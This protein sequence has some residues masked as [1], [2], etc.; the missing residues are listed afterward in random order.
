MNF[1]DMVATSLAEGNPCQNLSLSQNIPS[2]SKKKCMPFK[3]FGML[4]ALVNSKA[5]RA[6]ETK[7]FTKDQVTEISSLINSEQPEKA[8]YT[9]FFYMKEVDME[10]VVLKKDEYKIRVKP[11]ITKEWKAYTNGDDGVWI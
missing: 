5:F 7:G 6:G 4:R 11:D 1:L 2:K 10:H 3:T 8:L 9:F